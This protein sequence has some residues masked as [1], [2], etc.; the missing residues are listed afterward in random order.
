LACRSN[1]GQETDPWQVASANRESKTAVVRCLRA[2]DIA[3]FPAPGSLVSSS[4]APHNERRIGEMSSDLPSWPPGPESTRWSAR[5]PSS[6]LLDADTDIEPMRVCRT[7]SRQ[8]DT[9]CR[10]PKNCRNEQG[11]NHRDHRVCV[12]NLHNA[13]PPSTT[14]L[15]PKASDSRKRLHRGNISKPLQTLRCGVDG[16]VSIRVATALRGVV[17]PFYK[18]QSQCRTTT[19]GGGGGAT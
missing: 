10:I 7:R 9:R 11:N 5:T 8:S 17:E 15:I 6:L 18:L 13:I 1:R 14:K 2:P 4:T 16:V 19:A 12:H 3:F